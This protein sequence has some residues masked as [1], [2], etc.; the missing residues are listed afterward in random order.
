MYKLTEQSVTEARRDF[1]KNLKMVAADDAQETVVLVRNRGEPVA[2]IISAAELSKY[3]SWKAK[4]APT[5]VLDGAEHE[6][7]RLPEGW[8]PPD[9]YARH[10]RAEGCSEEIAVEGLLQHYGSHGLTPEDARRVAEGIFGE[11]EA[12]QGGSRRSRS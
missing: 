5:E 9:G 10:C 2:G 1:T 12:E 8:P 4:Q 3:F 7:L 11:G 6:G